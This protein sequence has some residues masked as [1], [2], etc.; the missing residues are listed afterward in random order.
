M[1]KKDSLLVDWITKICGIVEKRR[2]KYWRN[3]MD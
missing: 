2:T 1:L 3:H